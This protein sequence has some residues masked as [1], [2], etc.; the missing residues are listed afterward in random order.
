[1]SGFVVTDSPA[2]GDRGGAEP[3]PPGPG[4][5]GKLCAMGD[6]VSRRLPPSFVGPWDAWLQAMLTESRR[7]LGKDWLPA[8]MT[9]P[10]WRF[11]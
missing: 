8:Y 1:M 4:F 11:A 2:A 5:Y 3:G 10:I 6:F 9:A 7:H